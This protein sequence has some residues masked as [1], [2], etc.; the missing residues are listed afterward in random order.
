MKIIRSDEQYIFEGRNVI[1]LGNFDGLHIAH[2]Q[3]I[4]TAVRIAEER[5]ILSLLYYF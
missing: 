3:L 5:I 4:L 2:K 1:A